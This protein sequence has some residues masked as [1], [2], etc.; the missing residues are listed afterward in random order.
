MSI[1]FNRSRLWG[2]WTQAL[3]DE[4]H[5]A[6][7]SDKFL[8]PEGS[9]LV[10]DWRCL[11]VDLSNSI[12]QTVTIEITTADCRPGAHFGMAYIDF[13]FDLVPNFVLD[14]QDEYC[15]GTTI[16]AVGAQSSNFTNYLF[17]IEECL[18]Q[19]G[20]RFGAKEVK[21]QRFRNHFI[22]SSNL[23]NLYNSAGLNF[24]CGKYY[25]IKLAG[26]NDCNPWLETVKVIKIKCPTVNA[27][28]DR[29][30]LNFPCQFQIGSHPLS[31]YTYSWTPATNLSNSNI[32]NP[33][34]SIYEKPSTSLKYTV[35]V[36]DG[37]C[38]ATDDVE[39]FFE[40][41]ELISWNSQDNQCYKTY[42]L[43]TE[44]TRTISWSYND[45]EGKPHVGNGKI[46]PK[47]RISSEFDI[48]IYITLTNLC[49]SRNYTIIVPKN[50]NDFFADFPTIRVSNV[51][52]TNNIDRRLVA[53]DRSIGYSSQPAYKATAYDI[54]VMNRWGQIIY[55][56]ED[57]TGDFQNREINWMGQIDGSNKYAPIGSY[58]YRIRLQNCKN[59]SMSTNRNISKWGC[60]KFTAKFDIWRFAYKGECE[61]DWITFLC[62]G[63]DTFNDGP[64]VKCDN[65]ELVCLP[66]EDDFECYRRTMGY[67]KC[68]CIWNTV[69][70]VD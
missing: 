39:I 3:K 29:C 17:T 58:H 21:S 65:S 8:R 5:Y 48:T 55:F 69:M 13:C 9:H 54:T 37:E 20:T 56:K 30:C 6:D 62:G 46:I 25:R 32:A 61:W 41:P 49:G 15:E 34:C 36:N 52:P 1:K 59:T 50:S 35:T 4:F 22:P 40:L 44:H 28:A 63:D 47:V 67:W 33:L 11:S 53:Q 2:L 10:G 16:N 19:N 42:T 57:L 51:L 24:E 31:G 70:V 14:L 43:N 18:D 38:T 68:P 26:G 64:T 45:Y 60:A 7:N 23:T 27:G 12:G 66:H